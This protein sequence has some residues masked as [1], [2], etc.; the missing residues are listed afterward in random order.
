MLAPVSSPLTTPDLNSE[1]FG[2]NDR[3]TLN[4]SAVSA[5]IRR[6]W[7]LCLI[8]ISASLFVG[9]LFATFSRTY[10]TAYATILLEDRTSRPFVDPVGGAVP[11]DP[12]YVDSQVQVLQSDEVVGRAVDQNRLVE[13][14][15]FGNTQGGLYTP[16]MSYLT[17][18]VIRPTPRHAATTRV[19]RALSVRRVGLTN[20]VEIGF[21]SRNRERATAIANAIAQSYI[22]GQRQLKSRAVADAASYMHERL[23]ELRD[24][25]FAIDQQ[26]RDS[27]IN[28]PENGEQARARLREQQNRS[29]TYR[30]LYTNF[31]QRAYTE[32][33]QQLFSGARVITPAEPPMQRSWPRAMLVL[34]IA[35]ACGAAGGIAHALIKQATDT[36]LRTPEDVQ[37]STEINRITTI[38]KLSWKTIE[39]SDQEILRPAYVKWS[40]RLYGAMGKVAVR[41]QARSQRRRRK[42]QSAVIIGVVA[43]MEGA[44][45]SSVAVNL[46]KV[47][48]ESGQRTLL[49]DANWRGYRVAPRTPW[50]SVL[51]NNKYMRGCSLES[52]RTTNSVREKFAGANTELSQNIYDLSA[53]TTGLDLFTDVAPGEH[54]DSP[55][56]VLARTLATIDLETERLDVLVLRATSQISELSAALSIVKALEHHGNYDCVIVD[57]LST[58]QTADLEASVSLLKQVIVVVEAGRTTSGSL[59]NLMRFVPGDK[60][61]TVILNKA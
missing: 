27:S 11:A 43:P 48:A 33:Q 14:K 1:S 54:V 3:D 31:L 16:I 57:F 45:A 34:A 12:A 41:L 50:I 37:R 46:A 44:G 32:S 9:I 2:P 56:P 20:V 40:P 38:P 6:S 18:E 25:A 60:V 55:V 39:Q 15:E 19:M 4:I 5:F 26:A 47:I 53:G 24:K 42:Q 52:Q 59:H 29:E 10:Y 17:P 28:T 36:R 21:T 30:A 61:A 7:R 13:D 8:W 58:D 23:T 22:E 49:V 51:M 35:A